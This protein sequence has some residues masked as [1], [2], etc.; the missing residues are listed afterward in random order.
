MAENQTNATVETGAEETVT[1][2][3]SELQMLLQKE[4]DKRVSAALQKQEKKMAEATKLA[5]MNEQEKFSYQLE[6][7]EK[8]IAEKEHQLALAELKN[9]ASKILNEKGISLSLVDFVL[10]DDAET[11]N[12]K[13]GAL[14]KAFKDAV[15]VEVEKRLGGQAPI[16]GS[17]AAATISRK[18]FAK[19]SLA[20]QAKLAVEQPDLY[21]SL[22]Q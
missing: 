6:Q 5:A 14:D 8:A 13:I 12:S 18:Q 11:M 20:D 21:K 17:D 2:T 19:M 4:G 7:R 15:K 22:T 16:K 3:N 10:A 1:M 9:E